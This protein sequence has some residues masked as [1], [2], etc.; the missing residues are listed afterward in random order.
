MKNESGLKAAL[1][2]EVKRQ[3]PG[4]VVLAHA[5]SIRSGVPDWSVTGGGCT[6]W[7]EFKH[8]TP[9]F[10]SP[11]IQELTMRRLAAGGFARYVIWEEKRGIKRTLIIHP[12]HLKDRQPE[13]WAVGFD[14]RFVVDY[15]REAH[16]L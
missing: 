14:Y 2:R 13:V 8:A 15:L 9:D 7:W 6:T 10:A 5:D 3:L 4:L 16:R 12:N 1:L 11:G